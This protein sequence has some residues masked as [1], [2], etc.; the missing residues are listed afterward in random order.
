MIFHC[1][2]AF[3]LYKNNADNETELDWEFIIALHQSQWH[4]EWLYVYSI[5]KAKY[6]STKI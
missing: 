3:P 2:I 1:S 5:V 6:V 4:I